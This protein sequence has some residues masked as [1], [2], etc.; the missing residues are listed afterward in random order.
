[1]IIIIALS[2]SQ[3]Y[4]WY[5]CARCIVFIHLDLVVIVSLVFGT[6]RTFTFKYLYLKLIIIIIAETS[7]KLN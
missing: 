7:E 2:L 6:F 1:M 5:N 4:I 3:S